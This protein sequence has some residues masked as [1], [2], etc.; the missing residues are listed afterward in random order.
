MPSPEETLDAIAAALAAPWTPQTLEAVNQALQGVGRGVATPWGTLEPP[1]AN[2]TAP[3]GTWLSAEQALAAW[4]D[5]ERL[6]Y[7]AVSALHNAREG[8]SA[9]REALCEG[10]ADLAAAVAQLEWVADRL[11][12]AGTCAAGAAEALMRGDRP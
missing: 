10:A 3:A 12:W 7:D 8:L 2:A 6:N 11:A 9:A 1:L 5:P 4:R